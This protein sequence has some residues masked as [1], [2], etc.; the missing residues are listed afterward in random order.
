MK[1]LIDTNVWLRFF[2]EDIPEQYDQALK[3]FS[4]IERGEIT[5]YVSTIILLEIYFIFKKVYKQSD[6]EIVIIFQKILE[7]RGITLIEKTNFPQALN[8]L[9]LYH[10]KLSDCLIAS[11][12]PEKAVL[13]T[14][15]K[16]FS[17]IKEISSKKP[18][19]IVD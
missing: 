13:V 2:L 9:K 12:I 19:E 4:L 14:F 8:F 1:A 11:Q 6:A 18:D 16:E 7:F 15:D 10:I 17:K 5:P 3:L